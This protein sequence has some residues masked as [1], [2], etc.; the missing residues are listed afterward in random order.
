[1]SN[2]EKKGLHRKYSPSNYTFGTDQGSQKTAFSEVGIVAPIN[3]SAA[4]A[5]A[6]ASK[7]EGVC[8]PKAIMSRLYSYNADFNL[9]ASAANPTYISNEYFAQTATVNGDAL[10]NAAQ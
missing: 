8:F 9:P 6:Y 4:S 5:Q 2:K 7:F 1:M 3:A 10:L